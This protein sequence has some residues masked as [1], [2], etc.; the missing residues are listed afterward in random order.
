MVTAR[1]LFDG[2]N[3][4]HVNR[5]TRIRDQ[6]RSPIASDIKR[7]MRE[8]SQ[9]DQRTFA[10]TA[11]VTE[12]HR[13]VPIHAEDW[14]MLGCRVRPGGAVY[15]SHRTVLVLKRIRGTSLWR[16]TTTWRPQARNTALHCWYSLWYAMLLESRCHGT[17]H[18]EEM[19]QGF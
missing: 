6:E 3:G 11:D 4:T 17:K 18:Q 14:H 13:Q 7:M 8:K 12:A 10:L 1:V 19:T 2:S 15:E 16:T 9:I 5:R